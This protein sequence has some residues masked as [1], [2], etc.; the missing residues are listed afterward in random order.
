M[1]IS[2]IQAFAQNIERGRR[3]QQGKERTEQ[4]QR[5][6]MRF[7]RSQEQSQGR[8]DQES[9]PDVVT[10]PEILSDPFA[11]STPV[12]ELI[13]ARRVYRDCTVIVCSRQTSADLV[14]LEMMDFDAIMGMDWLS[15]CY[16]TVDCRAKAARFHFPG[17]AVLEWVGNTATPRG[18]FISYLKA[19]KM[20]AKGCIYHIVRVRDADAEISTLQSIPVVN[21]YADVFPD[22][23]PGIPPEREIDFSIDL[24]PG[25]QPISIPL[26]RMEPAELKELK[27][28][29]KDLLEKG[30]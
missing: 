21:E 5:K 19:R 16:A 30:G 14:E 18:K 7:P 4:G 23:L 9:S 1:D 8:Q 17:E 25:T 26:Y 27:E 29:L 24:L 11:V 12:G 15:A 10:V 20:I 2:R 28:Q 3:R 6:R 22:E 13:I